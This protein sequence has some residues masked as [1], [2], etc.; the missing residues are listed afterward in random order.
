MFVRKTSFFVLLLISLFFATNVYASVTPYV[1]TQR[2]DSTQQMGWIHIASSANGQKLI[3]IARKDTITNNRFVY[4]STNSG[5]TWEAQALPISQWENVAISSDGLTMVASGWYTNVYVSIDGGQTWTERVGS[6]GLKLMKMSADGSKIVGLVAESGDCMVVISDDLGLTW[7]PVADIGTN[8]WADVAISADGNKIILADNGEDITIS[9]NG[10]QTWSS[11]YTG[12]ASVNTVSLSANASLLAIGESYGH[13]LTSTNDGQSWTEFTGTGEQYWRGITSSNDGT[14]L[15]AYIGRGQIGSLYRSVNAG[16]SWAE[17]TDVTQDNWYSVASSLDGSIFYALGSNTHD[18]RVLKSADFGGT[19]NLLSGGSGVGRVNTISVASSAT[20]EK[21]AIITR[22]AGDTSLRVRVSS[23]SG[24]TWQNTTLPDSDWWDVKMSADGGY[25]YVTNLNGIMKVSTDFGSSW[26]SLAAD[27]SFSKIAVSDSGQ[28]LAL[29]GRDGNLYISHDYGQNI[30]S[31]DTVGNHIWASVT[32]SGGGQK[33][34][35]LTS[36]EEDTGHIYLSQDNGQT[37]SENDRYVFYGEVMYSADGSVIVLIDTTDGC[38]CIAGSHDAG[39]HWTEYTTAGQ[40]QWTA[41][42]VS[43]SGSKIAATENNFGGGG[44][45][46]TSIDAGNTW[47]TETSAGTALWSDIDSSADGLKLVAASQA[48]Y[49]QTALAQEAVEDTTPPV[50]APRAGGSSCYINNV[51]VPPPQNPTP[52]PPNQFTKNLQ[53][54]SIDKEVIELQRYL[55]QHG[56]IVSRSGAGAAGYETNVFGS[57]TRSALIKFQR[58]QKIVPAL[59]YFGPITR[60]VLN[61]QQ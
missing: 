45:V 24:V 4:I 61:S 8:S 58:A 54:G 57:K 59:G 30:L 17:L 3:A 6:G 55:N 36:G 12:V 34:A 26:T 32:M 23:N 11:K 33:I 40:K 49:V 53:L 20:G 47:T 39:L 14:Y 19:W 5:Q 10:G 35:A 42:T 48:G 1:W 21:L 27:L 29:L 50:P 37:W 31:Q 60:M 51:F 46:Y 41:V 28:H 43:Q 38:G 56:F 44:Y 7:N 13:I 9:T 2:I 18:N 52:T 16:V 15:I 22:T 25:L